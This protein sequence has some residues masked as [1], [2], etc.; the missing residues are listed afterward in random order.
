MQ[1]EDIEF[2]VPLSPEYHEHQR[3]R[4]EAKLK[5]AEIEKQQSGPHRITTKMSIDEETVVDGACTS[6]LTFDDCELILFPLFLSLG[7]SP[8]P[9]LCTLHRLVCDPQ[10]PTAVRHLFYLLFFCWAR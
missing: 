4:Q 8:P 2:V 10:V 9:P 6:M 3:A 7:S 1:R 5:L